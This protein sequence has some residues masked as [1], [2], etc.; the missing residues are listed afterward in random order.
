MDFAS[1]TSSSFGLVIIL[2]VW[3][4]SDAFVEYA[5][6]F[7]CKKLFWIKNYEEGARKGLYLDYPSYLLI[8]H[9]CFLTRLLSCPLCL[10]VWLCIGASC[11][12]NFDN[13]TYY[14]IITY[15]LYGV[16]VKLYEENI[17]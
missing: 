12:T 4:K 17:Q 6:L 3:F 16:M 10:S 13:F 9:N 14:F 5:S 1:I 15:A 7:G 11:V 8:H 2:L